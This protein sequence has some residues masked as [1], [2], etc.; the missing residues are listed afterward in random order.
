MTLGLLLWM[1]ALMPQPVHEQACLAA[2][3]YLEARDQS[4]LGQAAVAEVVLRRRESGRW[5]ET[6]CDVVLTHKQFA[7]A[8]TARRKRA[9]TFFTSTY[10]LCVV[11]PSFFGLRYPA[12]GR[13]IMIRSAPS[14][15][16]A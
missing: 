11:W 1:A 8:F 4:K 3:V 7:P 16:A 10:K 6:T 9:S 12:P 2:T 13:P 5:G 15:I 14:F